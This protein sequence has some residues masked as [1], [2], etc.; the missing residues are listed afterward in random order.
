MDITEYKNELL[1][2]AEEIDSFVAEL[3]AEPAEKVASMS[4]SNFDL[5]VV[6]QRHSNS[7]NA[8]LDFILK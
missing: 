7:G 4:E 5:G 8:L 3:E 6:S 2:V 1:K